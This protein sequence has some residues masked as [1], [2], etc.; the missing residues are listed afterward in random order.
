L[1]QRKFQFN[2]AT[3]KLMNPIQIDWPSDEDAV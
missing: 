3:V 2:N 1:D